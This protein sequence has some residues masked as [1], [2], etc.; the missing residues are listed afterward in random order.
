MLADHSSSN[1][2]LP[3]EMASLCQARQ[4][5][6]TQKLGD[7]KGRKEESVTK[8]FQGPG[9]TDPPP[10]RCL[11]VDMATS[12]TQRGKRGRLPHQRGRPRVQ[13]LTTPCRVF[14][15]SFSC[16]S[17]ARRALRETP[18]TPEIS[19]RLK[20][21]PL[22]LPTIIRPH[23]AIAACSSVELRDQSYAWRDCRPSSLASRVGFLHAL[24]AL[25]YPPR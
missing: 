9:T 7:E 14:L 17:G 11:G 8:I 23:C 13:A 25:L 4:P 10:A 12:P 21:F 3:C 15:S 19:W 6:R 18:A 20:M 24:F 2:R 16:G 5:D 22:P 1:S